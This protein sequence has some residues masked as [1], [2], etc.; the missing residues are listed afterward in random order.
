MILFKITRDISWGCLYLCFSHWLLLN[1]HSLD[2]ELCLYPSMLEQDTVHGRAHPPIQTSVQT[3]FRAWLCHLLGRQ[4]FASLGRN[5]N[6]EFMFM[7]NTHSKCRD[8]VWGATHGCVLHHTSLLL[9]S[10]LA[11]AEEMKGNH[12]PVHASALLDTKVG[13]T[14]LMAANCGSQLS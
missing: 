4:S 3:F 12:P 5:I 9:S 14:L 2:G 7:F 6:T 10:L 1:D 8:V 13:W 11:Q